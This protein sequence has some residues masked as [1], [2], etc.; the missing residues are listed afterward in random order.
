MPGDTTIYVFG[1][2]H[3]DRREGVE[4][5]LHSTIPAAADV[6]VIEHAEKGD[7]NP[8]PSGWVEL[9]NPVYAI[10]GRLRAISN[11]RK[12]TAADRVV[13]S[14]QTTVVEEV[15]EDFGLPVEFTDISHRRRVQLQPWYLTLISWVAT[16]GSAWGTLLLLSAVLLTSV[17]LYTIAVLSAIIIPVVLVCNVAVAHF[18]TRIYYRMREQKMTSDLRDVAD[19]HSGVVFFTG[20]SHVDPIRDRFD[21]DVDIISRPNEQ[22]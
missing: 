13:T 15:A 5:R 18:S 6:V 19:D 9:K 4:E 21:G 14:D 2:N 10:M 20:D 11:Y 1:D 22:S 17:S 16:L 8:D 12:R 3:T 7:E